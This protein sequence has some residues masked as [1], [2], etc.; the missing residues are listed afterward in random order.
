MLSGILLAG[1]SKTLSAQVFQN[2]NFASPGGSLGMLEDGTPGMVLNPGSTFVTGW[3]TTDNITAYNGPGRYNDAPGSSDGYSF[4]LGAGG[5]NGGIQQTFS[6]APNTQYKVTFWMTSFWL[7]WAPPELTV[8][9]A[10]QS[11]NFSAGPSSGNP[12][13]VLWEQKEF[14]FNSDG[15]GLAILKFQNV[16]TPDFLSA[17]EIDSVQVTQVPEPTTVSLA[18]FAVLAMC[19]RF[20]KRSKN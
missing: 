15:S 16:T 19:K 3:V 4:E 8:S 1:F 13:N 12:L 2:G 14:T 6:T 11:A 9:A 5:H 18:G 7:A 17:A 20:V 10:G